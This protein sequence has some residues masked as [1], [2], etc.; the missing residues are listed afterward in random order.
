MTT[1][2]G[3]MVWEPSLY[4]GVWRQSSQPG[5]ETEAAETLVRVKAESFPAFG[6]PKANVNFP[7]FLKNFAFR[8]R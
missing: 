4:T 8:N 3:H 7:L 1:F 2:R 5:L 6:C